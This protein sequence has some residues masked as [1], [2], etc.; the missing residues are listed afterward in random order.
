MPFPL[1]AQLR[2]TQ[3]YVLMAGLGK[4][5]FDYNSEI[6]RGHQEDW[7]RLLRWVKKQG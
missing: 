2:D 4:S 5:I 1:V 3:G 7:G 6:I